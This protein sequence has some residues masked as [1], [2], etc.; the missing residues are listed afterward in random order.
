MPSSLLPRVFD[1]FVQGPRTPDRRQGGLGLG[2]SLV[3]SLVSLHGGA[4]EAHSDGPGRGSEFVVRLPALPVE[5][6][7]ADVPS[8]TS[9]APRPTSRHRILLVDDNTDAAELLTDLLRGI[10]YEVAVAH[11]GP[12][13][14]IEAA[15]FDPDIA[16]LDIGLPVMD[17]YELARRLVGTVARP[18]FMIALTGY[19][20]ENDR[21]RAREAGFHEHMV[22]P[23]NPERLIKLIEQAAESAPSAG[24]EQR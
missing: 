2:L 6:V 16:I 5:L 20:Q 24:R 15:L 21:A 10:G 1:L 14:L 3:R 11:D 13:A 7:E 18:P 8:P 19:G 22:K 23:V 4:V 12:D 9:R 17:G